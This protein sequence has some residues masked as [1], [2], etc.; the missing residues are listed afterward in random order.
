MFLKNQF[1]V[2]ELYFKIMDSLSCITFTWNSKLQIF[3]MT[4]SICRRQFCYSLIGLHFIYMCAASYL[5]LHLHVNGTNFQT[6]F[7]A[8]HYMLLTSNWYCLLFR[9]L[10]TTKASE[11]V[12]MM[13]S[14]ALLEK[15]HLSSKLF[16]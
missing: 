5:F 16:I 10:Y 11:L 13:N 4:K 1:F 7:L 9:S 15:V 2:Y 6:A 12:S 14:I 8:C 3:A